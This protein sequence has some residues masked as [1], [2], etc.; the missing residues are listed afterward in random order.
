MSIAVRC[1]V[2]TLPRHILPLLIKHA[3]LC[4]LYSLLTRR[5]HL[6]I[7]LAAW[8][9][10]K[11]CLCHPPDL[12]GISII[13]PEIITAQFI[14]LNTQDLAK[15]GIQLLLAVFIQIEVL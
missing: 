1:A 11:V 4:L 14:R 15:C 7:Q 10:A 6:P 2:E 12:S 8:D 13:T 9:T 5:I 3:S